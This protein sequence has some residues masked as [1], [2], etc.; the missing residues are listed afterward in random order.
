[1]KQ[2]V[3]RLDTIW[4]KSGH[5]LAKEISPGSKLSL[6]EINHVLYRCIDEEKDISA[7]ERGPYGLPERG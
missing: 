4:N 7:N 2:A 6:T 5:Q 3:K 1:M